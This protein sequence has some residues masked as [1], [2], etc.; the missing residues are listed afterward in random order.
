MTITQ[1]SLELQRHKA[2]YKKTVKI[3][4][5]PGTG[6]THTLV[7]RVLKG[8]LSKGVLPIEIA[9]ISFTN[10]A[11][12]TAIDRALNAFPQFDSDDFA[13]F[14]TL[15]KFCRKY[16]EEEVFDPKACMLDYAL[17][18]K[19]IKTSD[20][21]LS[22]DNFTYKD[23]SLGVFD[24]ARNMMID[25]ITVYKKE[26]NKMDSLDVFIRK[27]DTYKH[28]K[29]DSFIDFT[30]MIERTIDEVD[31]PKLEVLILD[32][33][34]DFTPL[35]WSVL[36]KI[37]QQARRVYLAGD[38]DQG[39]Y[40]FNG[41]D[42]K[43]FTTYFPGRKVVLRQTRRFGEAIHHFSQIIRRGI[44]DSIEKD[45]DYL[46][47]KGFVKRYL[48][49]A[50]IPI[51]ELPGTWYLL[52]RIN[53]TVNELRSCAKDAGLYYGDN[54][55]NKSYDTKQWRAIKSWTKLSK[56]GKIGKH[57]AEIM[58]RYIREIKDNSYRRTGFWIDL[59]DTQQYDFDGLR[60]WCGLDLND[61]AATKPW[62][63]ILQRNF[64]ANQTEYFVRLLQRYGQNS[65]DD[66]PQIIIDTIHS[67]KGGE[68]SHVLLY[69]KANYPSSFVNKKSA[70]DKSD[71]K[72]VYYTGA[73]RAKDSLHILSSNYRYNYP[74]GEDYLIY[75]RE[76]K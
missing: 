65:L 42:P 68:A 6:K 33:A 54:K 10:K 74:I 26:Q 75:L 57:D 25:P 18:A 4:G 50:E 55:G 41:S 21:R 12:N 8:H 45:Y 23:W 64:T 67:V 61:E 28:Y 44:I 29:K 66:E 3:F 13:R 11:V 47:K 17:Q 5:P 46:S 72:R 34:Q 53:T 40:K 52:G 63:E 30:D 9:F 51:G 56:G 22:D 71:E 15:H 69:S 32:E 70:E 1:E 49:F 58:M 20:S 73:T 60:E 16:F 24:K 48:N 37:A 62:W 19:I 35:Q 76:K 31:F 2:L 43:Y 39:I 7:E 59:P 27:I 14:K 36:Y 38:D